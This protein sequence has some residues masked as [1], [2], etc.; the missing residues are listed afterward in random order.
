MN[1][2]C[3]MHPAQLT[4]DEL[5]QQHVCWLQKESRTALN[6]N[7]QQSAVGMVGN[8]KVMVMVMKMVMKMVMVKKKMVRKI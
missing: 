3:L 8:I 2:V 5:H 4:S 6:S 1:N 7:S